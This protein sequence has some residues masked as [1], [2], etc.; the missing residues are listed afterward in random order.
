LDSKKRFIKGFEVNYEK[1]AEKLA[2]V[3]DITD[4]KV[5]IAITVVIKNIKR[6]GY[7]YIGLGHIII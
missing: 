7:E 4:P 3:V 1:I 6:E 2:K 5:F